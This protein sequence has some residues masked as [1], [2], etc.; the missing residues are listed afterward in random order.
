VLILR[1]R[2]KQHSASLWPGAGRGGTNRP[3]DLLS[4][5]AARFKEQ[6]GQT[7]ETAAISALASLCQTL[8]NTNEFLYAP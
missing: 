5:Q 1:R 8:L 6:A 3:Q 2:S 4:K 7:D